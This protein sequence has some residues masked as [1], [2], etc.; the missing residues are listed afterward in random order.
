VEIS[1]H[2]GLSAK[3]GA[4]PHD[5]PIVCVG[6]SAGGLDAYIRLLQNLPADM[7]EQ[8]YVLTICSV[9]MPDA[10]NDNFI[11]MSALSTIQTANIESPNGHSSLASG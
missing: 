2:S 10:V 6:G 1:H 4:P 9:S 11:R 5:F 3:S 7:D 8:P